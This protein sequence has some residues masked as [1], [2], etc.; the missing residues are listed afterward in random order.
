MFCA[1]EDDS[2]F[3][4]RFLSKCLEFRSARESL[5]EF[6]PLFDRR[7]R[8]LSTIASQECPKHQRQ[9]SDEKFE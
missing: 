4:I 5:P 1:C 2:P 3:L 6:C 8:G 9:L 7:R